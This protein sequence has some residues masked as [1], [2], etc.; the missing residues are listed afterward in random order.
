MDKKLLVNIDG[1][2]DIDDVFAS[3]VK[4]LGE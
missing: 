3:I 4:I 2:Q 1:T